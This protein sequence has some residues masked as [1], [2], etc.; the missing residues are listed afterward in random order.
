MDFYPLNIKHLRLLVGIK[1]Q[2]DLGAAVGLVQSKISRLEN[3]QAPVDYGEAVKIADYFGITV[4]MLV[5]EDLT[6]RF[7]SLEEL[8]EWQSN[9]TLTKKTAQ[10]HLQEMTLAPFILKALLEDY[11]NTIA[12]STGQTAEEIQN[13]VYSNAQKKLE[14]SRP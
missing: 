5:K 13:R 10:E 3:G 14:A 8:T 12:A 11:S 7:K 1:K 6:Q 4:D 2:A 9:A